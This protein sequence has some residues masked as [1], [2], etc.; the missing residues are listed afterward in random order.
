[1]SNEQNHH[2][3]GFS[4]LPAFE[5]CPHY[6]GD[7]REG[8]KDAAEG[9]NAH[10]ELA[11]VLE[12]GALD[13][14]HPHYNVVEWAAGIIAGMGLNNLRSEQRVSFPAPDWMGCEDV[15][16]T[17]DFYSIESDDEGNPS[18]VVGDFKTFSDGAK[19]YAPQLMAGAMGVA[20]NH[21]LEWSGT[22]VNIVI[23]HGLARKAEAYQVTLGDCENRVGGIYEAVKARAISA[24]HTND[25]CQYCASYATCPAMRQVVAAATEPEGQYSILHNAREQMLAKPALAARRL[26]VIKELAKFLDAAEAD[27]KEVIKERGECDTDANGLR[28]WTL[29]SERETD[30]C[31]QI[32]ETPGNRKVKDIDALAAH[33]IND[34]G[35]TSSE[36]LECCT[37]K[38]SA[39]ETLFRRITGCKVKEVKDLIAPF[40]VRDGVAEKLERKA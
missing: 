10:A 35:A 29:R 19:N 34:H 20:N 27:C 39:L 18:I 28:T 37:V 9:T 23:L 36:I 13:L 31:W 25:W 11:R 7:D 22:P 26:V 21:G 38:M 40:A 5:A 6:T 16:G 24:P 14:K 17:P 15:F 3:Y 30:I 33:L 8:G 4:K 32:K 2:P 12:G 1:M